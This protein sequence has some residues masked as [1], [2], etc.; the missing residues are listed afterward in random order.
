M[1]TTVKT[2]RLLLGCL[3]LITVPNHAFSVPPEAITAELRQPRVQ[4]Y[5][6]VSS[7]PPRLKRGL[8][9]CF[10]QSKLFIADPK[11]HFADSALS[12]IP[13]RPEASWPT[14]RLIIAFETNDY[15]FVYYE[16]GHPESAAIVIALS[17]RQ[18]AIP[19]VVWSGVDFRQPYAGT[20]KQLA[21]RML[22]NEITDK[23]GSRLI[24]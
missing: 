20:P 23:Y 24:L 12:M 19:K 14:R 1:V 15:Y 16:K 5:A 2:M 18:R 3:V 4:T 17:K 21:K 8:Q 9:A 22:A 7:L 6:S 10:G 13:S 11:G